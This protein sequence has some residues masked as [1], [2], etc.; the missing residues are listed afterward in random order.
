MR[1]SDATYRSGQLEFPHSHLMTD[2]GAPATY[3]VE[4]ERLAAAL[5]AGAFAP[6]SGEKAY[7]SSD[8]ESLRWFPLPHE[9]ATERKA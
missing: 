3:L 7:V 9:V 5:P 8:F 2:E 4:A 6:T 1:L